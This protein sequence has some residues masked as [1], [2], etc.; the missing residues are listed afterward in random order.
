MQD[1]K[2]QDMIMQDIVMEQILCI[3]FKYNVYLIKYFS[4]ILKY[5]ITFNTIII[6][7]GS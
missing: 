2:T 4:I 1:V 7:V 6:T 5:F 3:Y